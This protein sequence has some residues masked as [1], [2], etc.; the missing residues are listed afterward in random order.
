MALRRVAVMTWLILACLFAGL[1]A[2]ASLVPRPV[3]AT[4][5]LDPARFKGLV[6]DRARAWLRDPESARFREDFVSAKRPVLLVCGELNQKNGNGAY[7]GFE[8]FIAWPEFEPLLE[9]AAGPAVMERAWTEL[10]LPPR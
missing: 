3:G 4:G 2:Y 7:A 1:F 5:I 10:C 9:S 8:R 6:E